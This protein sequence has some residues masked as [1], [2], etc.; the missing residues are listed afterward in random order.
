[1]TTRD[2]HG[3]PQLNE[4]V[5]ATGDSEVGAALVG[6]ILGGLVGGIVLFSLTN[7]LALLGTAVGVG[8]GQEAFGVWLGLSVA[9]GLL[10]AAVAGP[11]INNY[12][13]AVTWLTARFAPLRKVLVPLVRKSGLT[14]AAT[15]VG[16]LYGILAG[17]LVGFVAIPAAAMPG[18]ELP[19]V[20]TTV[21]F[22][23]VAFG[24]F[25]GVGY[26]LTL[27]GTVPLP[28]FSFVSPTARATVFAPVVA[29]A[30][31]GA[32]VY[33]QQT[34]Y[35]SYLGSIFGMVSPTAGF[36]FWMALTLLLGLFFAALARSHAARG[37]GTTGYGFVYGVVVAVFVGLL[38]VPIAVQSAT[39]VPW[40]F[41]NVAV[42]TLAAFV[43]YG[44]VLGSTF[45]KTI[46][47]QP[48]RPLFL[49][50][51]T[52]ATVGAAL[53]AGVIAGA[54]VY[55]VHPLYLLFVAEIVG[56]SGS[57]ATGFG[58][59]LA[60]FLLL[61]LAF[62]ALPARRVERQDYPGQTGF[63]LGTLYGILVALPV[64]A[65]GLTWL[66]NATAPHIPTVPAIPYRNPAV[67]GAFV[68]FGVVHGVT[69]GAI[70]NEGRNT[71]PFLHG[72]AL[73]VFGGAV[74]GAVAGAA[75]IY[76]TAAD[77][78]FVI[79]GG[80]A[81]VPSV[82]AGLGI[83]VGMAL[84]FGLLFVPLAARA[85]EYRIGIGRGIL[86]GAV[87][88]AV[89]AGVVGAVAVPAAAGLQLPNTNPPVVAYFVFGLV[90]GGVYAGLRARTIV[91]EDA[92]TSTAI[93]TKGQRAIVF[94]SLFGGA[95]GGLLMHHS[96]GVNPVAMWYFGA[97]AGYGANVT[98]GW[99]VWLAV[100]L[101]L[102]L[103]FAAAIGPR[104]DGY[105]TSMDGFTERDEDLDAAFG[106]YFDRAPVTTT[107]TLAGLGYGTLLAVSV[108][109]IGVPLLVNTT[110]E[111]GMAMPSLQPFFL[112]SFVLYGLVM[113]FGY[114]VFKEF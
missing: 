56:M 99:A 73:A 46:N 10:F 19:F 14:T 113:G 7:H 103:V 36:G 60:T 112:L 45:G 94:G 41:E 1:M 74:A 54:I 12:T 33:S 110:T 90:F 38:G 70:K 53:L 78:Y 49:V 3:Q 27:E 114:G 63:K 31:S 35:L 62:A 67:L 96:I 107:S 37:N 39:G 85:V 66:V 102:G 97:L 100:A 16:A 79:L 86:V 30:L 61:G 71:P 111:S 84:L 105:A 11:S 26:G 50:G 68:L 55:S 89:L 48:L 21:L 17:V 42:S 6:S 15:G 93:G 22:A 4:E 32:I 44:L 104:L 106:N 8:G 47:R 52:R 65:I 80:V 72:R 5:A 13:A 23:Y 108:G 18:V 2:A 29:G 34:M 98:V 51:R 40:G 75:V 59:V 109:A 28:S 81:G 83:W 20:N 87:Y 25:L 92:P 57:L 88:G 69:Y 82:G 43:V 91:H 95:V 58:I 76:V 101:F 77:V 9:L 64:G 24:I